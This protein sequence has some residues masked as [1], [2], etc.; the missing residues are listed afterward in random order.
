MYSI[1][2][3]LGDHN[4]CVIVLYAQT[5]TLRYHSTDGNLRLGYG[6]KHRY[7]SFDSDKKRRFKNEMENILNVEIN[8]III[9]YS[10]EHRDYE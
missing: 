1:K 10:V 6:I 4:N 9:N 3:L 7:P 8:E 2:Y 5:F